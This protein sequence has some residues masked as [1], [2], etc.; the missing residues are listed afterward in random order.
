MKSKPTLKLTPFE[1]AG[2]YLIEFA[3]DLNYWM[4]EKYLIS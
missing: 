2:Y 3:F 4:K 1:N